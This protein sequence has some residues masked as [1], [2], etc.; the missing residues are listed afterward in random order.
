MHWIALIAAGLALVLARLLRAPDK[1]RLMSGALWC[2]LPR[3][4][5]HRPGCV[6]G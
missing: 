1:S 3:D 5:V 6:G 2:G 4:D